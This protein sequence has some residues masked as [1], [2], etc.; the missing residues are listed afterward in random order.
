VVEE[1]GAGAEEEACLVVEEVV[2][3]DGADLEVAPGVAPEAVPEAALV[4]AQDLQEVGVGEVL[5]MIAKGWN[6]RKSECCLQRSQ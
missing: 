5:V 6:R 4:G 2:F 3:V 1:V